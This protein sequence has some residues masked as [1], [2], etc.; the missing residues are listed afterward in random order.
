MYCHGSL[1][2]CAPTSRASGTYRR[3]ATRPGTCA[4]SFARRVLYHSLKSASRSGAMVAFTTK[5]AGLAIKSAPDLAR[6]LARLRRRATDAGADAVEGQGQRHQ[7]VVVARHGLDHADGLRLR[8][9]HRLR[10]RVD[11]TAGHA[12]H[13]EAIDPLALRA[14]QQ[15]ALDLREQ[16][17]LV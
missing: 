5:R 2:G 15:D 4:A 10:Q 16:F 8:L 14:R 6:V 13:L 7:L 9:R 1:P 12:G 11:G 17:R 3:M